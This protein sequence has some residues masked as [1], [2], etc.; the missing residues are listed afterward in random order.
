MDSPERVAEAAWIHKLGPEAETLFTKGS[1]PFV[2]S[3]VVDPIVSLLRAGQSVALVGPVG[4]GKRS[5]A[6]SLHRSDAWSDEIQPTLSFDVPMVHPQSWPVYCTTTRHWIAGSFYVGNLENR[7]DMMLRRVKKPAIVLFESVHTAMGAWQ[8]RGDNLDLVDLLVSVVT[9]PRLRMVVTATPDG[10]AQ[11]RERKPDFAAQFVVVETPAP[12]DSE[13]RV[14][15]ALEL[16][17]RGVDVPTADAAIAEAFALAD[18]HFGAEPPLGPALRLLRGALSAPG[19]GVGL[20]A[21]RGACAAHLGMERRWVGRDLV[22]SAA[23]ILSRLEK[24]V[25]GQ[26]E[27]C[28]A[29]VDDLIAWLYGLASPGRAPTSSPGLPVSVRRASPA[30][31]RTCSAVRAAN[32]CASTAPSSWRPATR[33]ACSPPTNPTR[34][35]WGSWSIRAPWSSS[36]RSTGRIRS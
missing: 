29:V 19:G 28:G 32:R 21:I 24:T 25:L 33:F 9:H 36:T 23:S 26:H 16:A 12:S 34:S 8:G 22:P 20:S 14:I 31:C 6:L 30:P 5:L 7:V 17:H 35:W 13:S 4:V 10:W 2:R 15:A 3:A 1:E 11:I 27:A 18:R